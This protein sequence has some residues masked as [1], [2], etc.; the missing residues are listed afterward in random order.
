MTKTEDNKREHVLVLDDSA[1]IRLWVKKKLG[2]QYEVIQAENCEHA[3]KALQAHPISLLIVDHFLPDITGL[4]F[5]RTIRKHDKLKDIPI[6]MITGNNR[7]SLITDAFQAGINDFLQKPLNVHEL[8]AR[9]GIALRF[10]ETSERLNRLVGELRAQ[11]EKDPLT[12]LFNRRA[13]VEHGGRSI[14]HA[15]RFGEPVAVLMIDL[16]HFKEINDEH[17]HLAGD[18]VLIQFGR[19]VEQNLRKYDFSAR[20]GGDE[21]VAVLPRVQ[22][23]QAL[24]AATKLWKLAREAAFKWQEETFEVTLSVGIHNFDGSKD[25]FLN[26]GQ[27]FEALLAGADK[28]LYQAKH[29]GRDRIVVFTEE[30]KIP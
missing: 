28:A 22:P 20:F 27:E 19:L 24:R 25:S 12:G 9:V 29:E 3:L 26:D 8:R 16:D 11:S 17:G 1:P 21:F 6:V 5:S 13:L 23:A 30:E 2:D 7:D 14:A 18:E 10:K 15:K 4:D